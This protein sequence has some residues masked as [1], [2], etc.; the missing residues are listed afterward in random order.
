MQRNERTGTKNPRLTLSGRGNRRTNVL[1]GNVV[2]RGDE[3]KLLS[4]Q[5]RD[6]LFFDVLRTI[7][8]MPSEFLISINIYVYI[9]YERL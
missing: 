2:I 4:F 7:L 5:L 1:E 3:L 6:V 9:N 8:L